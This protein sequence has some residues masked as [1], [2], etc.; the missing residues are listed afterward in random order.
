MAYELL[1]FKKHPGLLWNLLNSKLPRRKQYSVSPSRNGVFWL[2]VTAEFSYTEKLLRRDT[3]LTFCFYKTESISQ[4]RIQNSN[5]KFHKCR[6]SFFLFLWRQNRA[7]LST[8]LVKTKIMHL[9]AWI[10]LTKAS[11]ETSADKWR[12]CGMHVRIVFTVNENLQSKAQ[13]YH[14]SEAGAAPPSHCYCHILPE[15]WHKQFDKA[16]KAPLC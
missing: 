2:T 4:C 9:S 6:K 15:E 14:S 7:T 3:E 1:I 16:R 11:L 12:Y 10:S 13:L 8:H 5:L